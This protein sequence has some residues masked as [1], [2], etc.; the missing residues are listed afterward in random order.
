MKNFFSR[1]TPLL[2][3][4]HLYAWSTVARLIV[5]FATGTMSANPIQELERRTGRHAV[6]LLILSLACTPINTVFKWSEPIKRRRALGLYAFMYAT[7]H[8]IIFADLDYGFAWSLF[9]KTVLKKPYILVGGAS[10]LLLVPLAL[11]S[12]DVWK[13]R[14]GKNWRR[15]HQLIYLIAPLALLHFAWSKKGDVF[16][17]QGDVIRPLIY[18]LVFAVFL[19]LRIPAIRKAFASFSPRSLLLLSRK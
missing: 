13:K 18:G 4:V 16:A 1:Y 11:T 17:L 12:F 7:I 10:F 2:I 19:V 15:L 5:E 8:V 14:F 9:V 3:A 6:T